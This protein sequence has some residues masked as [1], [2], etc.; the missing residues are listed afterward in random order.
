[1]DRQCISLDGEWQFFCDPERKLD[2]HLRAANGGHRIRVP[3]PWQATPALRH[4]TEVGW[5]RREFDL[6]AGAM[7]TGQD[8]FLCFGAVDYYAKVWLNG[9]HL[10][11]HEGGYLPFEFPVSKILRAEGRN[12]VVVRVVDPPNDADFAPEFAFSEIP[13]GKQSW[14]GEMSGLW[15]SVTLERR[16]AVHIARLLVIPDVP[17]ARANVVVY[18]NQPPANEMTLALRVTDQNGRAFEQQCTWLRDEVR[19]EL[20]VAIPDPILWDT[21]APHLYRIE[22]RWGDDTMTDY[23]GMRTITTSEDG[24]LRLNGRILF[25]R[26]ALD[27]AYYPELIYSAFSDEQLDAQF[28]LAKHM[29]LNCIRTHIKI[30]EP[31]YYAAAD[32]AGLLIW[33]ELPNWENLSDTAKRRARDTLTGMVLRDFNHPS[34][35]IWTIINEGWGLDL[36]VNADH[37]AWLADMYVYLKQLD[38]TRLAVGN[39]PCFTNFHVVTDIEDFHNYYAIPDH[40]RQWQQWVEAF[41]ARPSW[42]FAHPYEN[43]R[44]WR[45]FTRDPWNPTPRTPAPEVRRRG[46]EPMVVSEFGNWGLPDVLQLRECYGG[47]EPWWFETGAD[48]GGGVVYPHGIEQRFREY[49]LDEV[50]GSLGGLAS[51]SQRVQY[52]ALKYQIEQIRRYPSIVGYI[53]TEFTDLHWEANGL[54][55][56]CRNPKTFHNL[57]ANV[58]SADALVPTDWDRVVFCAGE[59]CELHLSCSH[60]SD[61]DLHHPYVEWELAGTPEI[62]GRFDGFSAVPARLTSVGTISFVV[63]A[64]AQSRRAQISFHLF[65]G[66]GTLVTQNYHE[67]YFLPCAVVQPQ[68]PVTLTASS[69]R[70]GKRL[71]HLGY[72]VVNDDTESAEVAVVDTLT[73]DWRLHV[74]RGGKVLWLADSEDSQQTYLGAIGIKRRHGQVWQGDWASSMS[75]IRQDR[76]FRNIPSA[77]VVD[78]AFA[79]LTPEHVIDGLRPRDFAARVY[80][81][82]FVGWLH[83]HVALVAERRIGS[84]CLLLCTFRLSAHLTTNPLAALMLH[85]M[86]AHL[87][88]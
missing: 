32:R 18:A 27:Q 36:A 73:D 77:G 12:E 7:A 54:L 33:S 68:R 56:I 62:R 15:Q 79:D 85:D 60:F 24:H 78:F 71:E 9:E 40:Y 49:H 59:R 53:I 41:A 30:N 64:T 22:A 44:A 3:A 43:I 74:Q 16:P 65:N 21:H 35:V 20:T 5:Y 34:I 37:R 11:D 70:L 31:R 58:N 63:P 72:R 19:A 8:F 66:D 17:G 51:A 13:H 88:Q 75:W 10:G 47:Q 39:S 23:F 1:M 14:Y 67:V 57:L 87:A 28:A 46:S 48:W 26:G 61:R 29:G 83:A 45:A 4:Y 2:Q 52:L 76:L 81:G 50:F 25:L 84:G 6:P 82:M 86:I 38:P 80:A 69:P 55:D 42:T